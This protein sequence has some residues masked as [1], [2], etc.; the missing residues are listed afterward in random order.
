MKAINITLF[1]VAML[2]L[3]LAQ[4]LEYR[5]AYGGGLE[6]PI[7]DRVANTND[8]LAYQ[9]IT[10]LAGELSAV[11]SQQ[12]FWTRKWR[13]YCVFQEEPKRLPGVTFS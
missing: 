12:D 6:I 13:N 4:S 2:L 7:H 3:V 8:C 10:R 9:K 5:E 1:A 11:V